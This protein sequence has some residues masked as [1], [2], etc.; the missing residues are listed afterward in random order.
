M[1]ATFSIVQAVLILLLIVALVAMTLPWAIEELEKAMDLT[2]LNTIKPQ[3]V[4]CDNKIIETARTGSANKCIF[5]IKRGG[6]SG[7]ADGIY[8]TLLSNAQICD[9]SPLTEIDSESHIWQECSASGSQRIYGML[10]KFPSSLNVTGTQVQGDQ[11]TGTTTI[12]DINF[13]SPITFDTLTLYVNFQ[14]STGQM[15]NV[16]ELSR[17]DV[18]QTNVTLKI[19]IS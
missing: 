8:Y 5:N 4:D 2:E 13:S 18:T 17:V 10:W 3:F 6:I 19:K 11:M 12:K 7:R 15:G 16:V 9:P 14:Y 1:K